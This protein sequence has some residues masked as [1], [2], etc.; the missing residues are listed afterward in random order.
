MQPIRIAPLLVLPLVLGL[1]GACASKP[2]GPPPVPTCKKID[3]NTGGHSWVPC[4][5]A[6]GDADGIDD[7]VDHCPEW[8]ENQNDLEDED[9]C[10]DPDGDGDGV[11]DVEDTCPQEKGWPPT[12][13]VLRDRDEDGLADHLDACPDRKEDLDGDADSDG[14]P[15]GVQ[16]S[17]AREVKNR[18]WRVVKVP[19]KKGSSRPTRKGSTN[20]EEVADSLLGNGDALEKI[21]VVGYAAKGEARGGRAR[22]RLARARV[23]KVRKAL[24]AVVR[25]E[26]FF[27]ERI[28]PLPRADQAGPRVEVFVFFLAPE[29]VPREDW[30]AELMKIENLG[31]D[32]G[33]A[34]QGSS[35]PQDAPPAAE[36]DWDSALLEGG[37]P[38]P[39]DPDAP[40][41]F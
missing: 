34:S 20:L 27:E 31:G 6:D 4:A 1:W 32:A 26:G 14:C 24:K 41:P 8:P 25:S 30:D 12:G 39:K 19:M 11:L 33:A 28:Y 40:A 29:N 22:K 38:P 16:V 23:R 17:E 35:A 9:G 36:E 37:D 5:Q 10:P 2:K 18:L 21:R 3:R 7:A 13:C 15:E